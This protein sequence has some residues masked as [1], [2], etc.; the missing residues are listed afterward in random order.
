MFDADGNGP[1]GSYQTIPFNSLS[2]QD[3]TSAVQTSVPTLRTSTWNNPTVTQY[4]FPT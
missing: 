2:V 1:D 3:I 4:Q